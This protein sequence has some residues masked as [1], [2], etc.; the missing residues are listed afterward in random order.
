MFS[1]SCRKVSKAV[2][3]V[4]LSGDQFSLAFLDVSERTKAV[5]LQLEDKLI[6]I[7]RLNAA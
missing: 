7:E 4:S 1:D 3:R 2:E 6:G 5:N